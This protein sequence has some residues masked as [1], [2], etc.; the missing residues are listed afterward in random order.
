MACTTCHSATSKRSTLFDW[1]TRL[2]ASL[3]PWCQEEAR[4][5]LHRK[6]VW[7]EH[8][9]AEER[10]AARFARLATMCRT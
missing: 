5:V 4:E 6:A 3:V 8:A 9:A 7:T 10:E 2:L 1:I